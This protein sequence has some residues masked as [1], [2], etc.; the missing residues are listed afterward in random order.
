MRVVQLDL[1][2]GVALLGIFVINITLFAYSETGQIEFY[3][4]LGAFFPTM[5]N[6]LGDF[7]Y[8]H[9]MLTSYSLVYALFSQKMMTLFSFLFGASIILI[10][11]KLAQKHGTSLAVFY[12][13]NFW[14]MVIGC[15]HL[16]LW[17]G[18]ILFVYAVA[19]FLLYPLRRMS[20]PL[21][22][23]L[24]LP[25]YALC[26]VYIGPALA[27]HYYDDATQAAVT[28]STGL[29]FDELKTIKYF[30]MS[31]ANMLV[32]MAL[33][34][35]GYIT[36]N[37]S[38]RVYRNWAIYGL[39][40]GL[41]LQGLALVLDGAYGYGIYLDLNSLAAILQAM[42][43]IGILVIWSQ[44][45]KLLGLQLRFQAI[46]RA[47]LTH[48]LLQTLVSVVLFY[49]LLFNLRAVEI[50]FLQQ[51]MVVLAVWILQLSLGKVLMEKCHYG[52]V[53]W[54]WRSLYYWQRQPFMRQKSNPD[55]GAVPSRS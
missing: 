3:R 45:D 51:M 17:Y 29:S 8:S 22:V 9:V 38:R 47:A 12:R 40:A 54:L 1:I 34:K 55:D 18:D 49:P 30:S 6:G 26:I 46:G 44:S 50:D 25:M 24:S 53:E 48:Y 28:A 7:I 32:G 43:Y 16:S 27:G 10:T 20:A 37:A 33:Y 42:A 23:G 15:L 41:V 36:G 52:P 13:R 4:Q 5:E 14:L 31:M 39:L 11:E 21:L 19:G 2:R 35:T